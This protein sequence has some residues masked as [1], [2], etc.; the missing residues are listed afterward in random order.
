MSVLLMIVSLPL[1]FTFHLHSTLTSTLRSKGTSNAATPFKRVHSPQ[2]HNCQHNTCSYDVETYVVSFHSIPSPPLL[3]SYISFD[4]RSP[5]HMR[6][7]FVIPNLI[8]WGLSSYYWYVCSSFFFLFLSR[9]FL[10]LFN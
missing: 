3:P 4:S 9:S 7:G 2:Y 1:C 5:L 8:N 10:L 6:A